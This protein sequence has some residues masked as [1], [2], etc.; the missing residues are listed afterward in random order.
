MY[1]SVFLLNY[2]INIT[3][4]ISG[5]SYQNVLAEWN[6]YEIKLVGLKRK[7]VSNWGGFSHLKKK[8]NERG[9]LIWI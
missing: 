1:V 7:P 2:L 9:I 8:E 4:H 5:K 6:S 3:I